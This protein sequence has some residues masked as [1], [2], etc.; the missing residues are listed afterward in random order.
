VHPCQ[1]TRHMANPTAARTDWIRA[2]DV[3]TG[4]DAA[5][6]YEGVAH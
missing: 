1:P 4:Q 2:R 6:F 3:I 5:N